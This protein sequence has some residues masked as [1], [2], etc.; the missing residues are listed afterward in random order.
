MTNEAPSPPVKRRRGRP[1]VASRA[2]FE[3]AASELFL[4]RGYAETSID[5]IA[6]RAGVARSSF[7]NYFHSKS[8][9]LW[10]SAEDAFGSIVEDL[11]TFPATDG[12]PHAYAA[13]RDLYLRHA[14][15]LEPGSIPWSV[16]Q[17]EI[18][19]TAADCAATGVLYAMR[20]RAAIVRLLRRSGVPGLQ[21]AAFASAFLAGCVSGAAEWVD[22][23]LRRGGL[24]PYLEASVSPVLRG[25]G[26]ES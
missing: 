17:R 7:F 24:L 15:R 22:A 18:M 20:Q 4:E 11:E 23:G 25:F 16:S 9:L 26:C 21:A 3:E 13:V 14:A 10:C 6:R 2:I 19:G 12:A 5:D 1:Q 8:D